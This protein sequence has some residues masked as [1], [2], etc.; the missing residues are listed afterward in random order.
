MKKEAKSV[1]PNE[2]MSNKLKETLHD[3]LLTSSIHG[4]PNIARSKRIF[5]K[6]MWAIAFTILF[7]FCCYSIYK[8]IS[9][10]LEYKVVTEIETVYEQ[11]SIF[12]TIS[13]CSKDKMHF[14][15]KNLSDLVEVCQFGYDQ[16]CKQSLNSYFESYES[17]KYGKCFRFNSGLNMTA[18]SIPLLYSPIGGRDDSFVLMIEAPNGLVVW[19]H[20]HTSPPRQENLNGDM[21]YA[22][23]AA[24]TQLI[25]EREFQSRLEEPYGSCFKN[26]SNF[27]LNKTLVKLFE[28]RNEVYNHVYCLEYCF[29]L[30]Y[31]ENNYC[32][33]SNAKIGSVWKE[34]YQLNEK[35]N[36]QGCTFKAK[37]DFYKSNYSEYC[38]NY[39]PL[40]CDTIKYIVNVNSA[41]IGATDEI[42]IAAYYRSLK[43][44]F[45]SQKPKEQIID[46]VTDVGGLLGLF[47]GISFMS[48][49]EIIHVV[50]EI[51]LIFFE[52]KNFKIS[53]TCNMNITENGCSS[54]TLF[55]GRMFR[56][57]SK[58]S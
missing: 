8:C 42:L 27:N 16:T 46:F 4:L 23:R 52:K 6:L 1:Q 41:S 15:N 37:I 7:S 9:A 24:E 40:E 39:C 45:S 17:L 12:P 34:C 5:H 28:S 54:F 44:T 18:H 57:F 35:S 13:F 29:D 33:C 21:V 19:V 55:F 51:I 50:S 14:N 53:F 2:I 10:Y 48:F 22:S 32:N 38:S 31:I 58:R 43:Y 30:K 20:N 26:A 25:I 3:L 49:V 36:D 11:P 47:V 56:M